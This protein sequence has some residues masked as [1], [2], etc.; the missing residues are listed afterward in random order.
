ML[1][2]QWSAENWESYIDY[3]EGMFI[4]FKSVTKYTP[5]LE[6][7][8]DEGIE[9]GLK[10]NET[11]ATLSSRQDTGL[12]DLMT[13]P[14]SPASGRVFDSHS[15]SSFVDLQAYADD[16]A[17]FFRGID[18]VL[19]ETEGHQARLQSMLQDLEKN[20][21]LFND[22]LQYRNMRLGEFFS[23]Q[24]QM[25]A[26][27][28]KIST[29]SMHVMTIKTRREAVSMH[30]ITIWTLIFLPGTFVAT[31]F[32]SGILNFG[33]GEVSSLK[34]GEWVEDLG[35]NATPDIY[36]RRL[37][38]R[39][40]SRGASTLAMAAPSID[41]PVPRGTA[42]T[43]SFVHAHFS[44]SIPTDAFLEFV[45]QKRQNYKGKNGHGEVQY[46]LPLSELLTYWTIPRIR[47]ACESYS[48]RIIVKHNVIRDRFLRVFST[49]VYIG[50]L[51]YLPAFQRRDL[52]DQRFPD[53]TLPGFWESSPAHMSMF[54]NFRNHQWMFFP[55]I[56]DRDS[57]DDRLLP[58]EQILPLWS[59]EVIRE[60]F[61]NRASI[62]KIR[63][64][65]SCNNLI[66]EGDHTE[67][68]NPA[69]ILKTYHGEQH[70]QH[71][72]HEIQAFARLL[73][74]PSSTEHVV[75]CHATFK[76]GETYNLVMEWVSG[77]DLLEY[78]GKT[79]P[80][81][82]SED[83]IDFWE[84]LTRLVIGLYRIHQI[85]VPGER[86]DRYQLV[87][88]DIKP[89]NILL[90]FSP[91][92]GPYQFNPI[93]ADLGHSHTRHIKDDTSDVP[94]V[95]RRGNQTYCAPESSHHAGFRRTGSNRIKS[96]ADIFSAGAV[97][98]EAASWVAKGHHGRQEYTHRR[99]D[100]LVNTK[101]FENSG[102]ETAFHDGTERL[103]CVDEM[104]LDILSNVPSYDNMTPRVLKIIE[105]YMMVLPNSR[106]QAGLLYGM[107]DNEVLKARK[108]L[109]G[110]VLDLKKSQAPKDI[111]LSSLSGTLPESET[112]PTSGKAD[113]I[114][115]PDSTTFSE[116][117][118]A[119]GYPDSQVS[120]PSRPPLSPTQSAV[121][122][123]SK[124]LLGVASPTSWRPN[125]HLK[126]SFTIT[127][128]LT[129]SGQESSPITLGKTK[130]RSISERKSKLTM[131]EAADFRHAKKM[132]G[133][134]SP[135]VERVV[136]ELISNLQRRDHLF[137][138]DDTESMKEHSAQIVD[139][140][141]TLAYIAKSMDPDGVELS[142]VSRPGAISK[143][144]RTG[145]LV[146]ELKQQLSS[147]RMAVKGRIEDSLGTLIHEKI[148]RR[149]PVPVPF[150]GNFPTWAKP[151]TIFVF[152]D[153]KWG[154]GIR[155]GNGLDTPITNLMRKVKSRGLNRQHV[156]LQ[157][158][159][160]G[161]DKE[162]MKHLDHLDKFGKDEEWDIV[163]TRDISGGDVYSMFL[164]AL[165]E[166]N[167]INND[168]PLV[169]TA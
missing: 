117:T 39:T 68:A 51:S 95:D 164:A 11:W 98:S 130:S 35:I 82:T 55:V 3:L 56:I 57:L 43:P 97:F 153:G 49:L 144:R 106:L 46:Y 168:N 6:L 79:R 90:D 133:H 19:R 100:S 92:S 1:I 24:G 38:A 91:G 83:I 132:N 65:P 169:S 4:G 45:Q 66:K 114:W 20:T 158:L 113:T 89:D 146:E 131:G 17:G 156:M 154:E 150:V 123:V 71:Y 48:E 167:D 22:I 142:F 107:F 161:H 111:D 166:H 15:F 62:T 40:D 32:S 10:K 41:A 141:Q 116:S 9:M 145:P 147:P 50:S 135:R 42:G 126:H 93:I 77:G 16:V 105:D 74:N 137:L 31:F 27:Q 64:H 47:A 129:P 143:N 140:F 162:G 23:K 63:F 120:S 160:F 163:D 81:R 70:E 99:R 8:K 152:T 148:M 53:T 69:Y 101:G 7:A 44:N 26:M 139:S 103:P 85:V 13:P 58:P 52:S 29:D 118:D 2:F 94:G 80:P 119:R 25:L 151:M 157:F 14:S 122:D 28:A 73:H 138:I 109:S 124:I 12:S 61:H 112:P 30:V 54:E 125:G 127:P 108:E 36:E 102:Y 104:H 128:I 18:K 33:D 96:D 5:V 34:F 159:R 136:E 110:P 60:K 121:M 87:H 88:Q 67:A 86:S 115:S 149:L 165:T 76:H 84:S 75:K 134:V 37:R 155:T 72:Q 59:E 78:F 21:A